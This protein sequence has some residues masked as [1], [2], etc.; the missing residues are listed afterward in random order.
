M[1]F[2]NELEDRSIVVCDICLKYRK[3]LDHIPPFTSNY[4]FQDME[5]VCLIYTGNGRMAVC[6]NCK[7][8]KLE[9]MNRIR[10]NNKV[11]KLRKEIINFRLENDGWS[12]V[13]L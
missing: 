8:K 12:Q 6:K 4:Q 9:I 1:I 10:G 13:D 3:N 11:Y 2:I 5:D 7:G